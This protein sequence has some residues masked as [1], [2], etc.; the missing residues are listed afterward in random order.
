MAHC[1][2][3]LDESPTEIDVNTLIPNLVCYNNLRME[4]TLCHALKGRRGGETLIMPM[5]GIAKK[6]GICPSMP[7][8]GCK[9]LSYA[10]CPM[11]HKIDF[12]PKR[13][14]LMF[15]LRIVFITFISNDGD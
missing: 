13:L 8:T 2:V 6:T 9:D 11:H 7:V 10:T 12:F 14:I 4:A 1:I 3:S 5:L 15:K